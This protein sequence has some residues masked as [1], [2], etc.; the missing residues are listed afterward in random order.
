MEHSGDKKDPVEVLDPSP[1]IQT[2]GWHKDRIR[3]AGEMRARTG[4]LGGG[5]Y[6]STHPNWAGYGARQT[7]QDPIAKMTE[8]NE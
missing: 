5:G 7:A 8:E 4:L 3:T 6:G 2:C 1:I